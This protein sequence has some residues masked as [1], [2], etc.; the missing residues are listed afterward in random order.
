MALLVL[1]TFDDTGSLGSLPCRVV[2]RPSVSTLVPAHVWLVH[3]NAIKKKEERQ[4]R[5][6]KKRKR[7][8]IETQ[9]VKPFTTFKAFEI[10]LWDKEQNRE[11]KKN[12]KK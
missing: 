6:V 10:H 2:Y 11:Q 4:V 5:R 7:K 1:P 8:W 3:I 9:R 12:K